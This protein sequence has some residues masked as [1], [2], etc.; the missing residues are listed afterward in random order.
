MTAMNEKKV[1]V[2]TGGSSGIGA[3]CCKAFSDA[4]FKVYELS[5]RKAGGS[6]SAVHI[7]ADVTDG[8]SV[9]A[10]FSRIFD[11]EGRID[12]LVNNA[13]FG[14]SG[15]VELTELADAVSQFDVNFFGAFTC[16]KTAVGYMRDAGGG[17]IINVSSVAA[18]APIPFQSFYSASKA[19]I[20]SFTLS[21]ANELRPF[22]IKVCAVMPGDVRTGFTDARKKTSGGDH[23]SEAVERSVAVMEKDERNGMPPERIARAVLSTAL[24]RR[25]R[26]LRTVGAQYHAVCFLLKLLPA[27]FANRV[28]GRIYG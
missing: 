1:A 10:A 25:P 16:A 21:L 3:A 5:R 6:E 13:G 20:N 4:G 11:A 23:Y 19:A 14:I 22:N 27:S 9:R 24:R 7:T 26:P 18:A 8:D 28:I 17:R 15:P 2:I 12:V